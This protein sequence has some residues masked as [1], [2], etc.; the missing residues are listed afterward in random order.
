MVFNEAFLLGLPVV[1]TEFGSVNE[2]VSQGV[3]GIISPISSM[4]ES[5]IHLLGDVKKI[6]E[7][8]KNIK[9]SANFNQKIIGKL[10]DLLSN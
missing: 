10:D 8:K 2:F 3:N 5:L 1:T 9:N 7:Y 6:N 4:S